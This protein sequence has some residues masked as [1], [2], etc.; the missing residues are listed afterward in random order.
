LAISHDE[1]IIRRLR[2]DP[3]FAAEYIK[4]ALKDE[5]EP[6]VLLITLRHP[7]KL[8]LSPE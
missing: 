6:R 2:K 3:Q 8:A 5:D 7:C 4:T 1:T